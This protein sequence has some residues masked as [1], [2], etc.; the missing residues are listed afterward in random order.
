MAHARRMNISPDV[1]KALDISRADIQTRLEAI[2]QHRSTLSKEE[3]FD[4][5]LVIRE[6]ENA[7][8]KDEL[9][10]MYIGVSSDAGFLDYKINVMIKRFNLPVKDVV[11]LFNEEMNDDEVVDLYKKKTEEENKPQPPED[12]SFV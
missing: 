11:S 8:S 6:Y 1:E 12:E 3:L 9:L 10:A 7:F 4:P 2:V 5:M